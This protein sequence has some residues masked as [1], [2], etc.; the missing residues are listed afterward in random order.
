MRELASSPAIL[1]RL[2]VVLV[3]FYEPE[4][5]KQW[6]RDNNTNFPMYMDAKSETYKVLGYH[7]TATIKAKTVFKGILIILKTRT[8]QR[9]PPNTILPT[10]MGGNMIADKD[11]KILYL[12]RSVSPDDRPSVRNILT[13]LSAL[14]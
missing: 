14:K 2:N 4:V 7:P 13:V 8:I 12:H 6:L 1:D 3:S 11:G 5:A 9:P 10:Q